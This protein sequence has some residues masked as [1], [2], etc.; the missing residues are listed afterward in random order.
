MR[1]ALRPS[2]STVALRVTEPEIVAPGL[3]STTVGALTST[4]IVCIAPVKV[5]PARSV[6]HRLKVVAAGRDRRRIPGGTERRAGRGRDRRPR[7][8][9]RRAELVA[10]RRDAG[11]GVGVGAAERNAR[12][13]DGGA[14]RRRRQRPGGCRVVDADVRADR[15]RARCGPSRRSRWR[16]SRRDRRRG[17]S[18]RA[19]CPTASSCRWR[20][21]PTSR[22]PPAAA[23][24]RPGSC[25][26]RTRPTARSV[27]FRYWPGS[28]SVGVG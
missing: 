8:A 18:C 27:P 3:A 20:S 13:A 24:S 6:M 2:R 21:S 10:H 1:P 23:R 16:G 25:P 7:T 15:A 19:T 9:A 4:V 12:A 26:G 22:R 5:L 14:V 28:A 17:Q 11:P